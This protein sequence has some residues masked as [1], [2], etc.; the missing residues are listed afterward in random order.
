MPVLLSWPAMAVSYQ[1][2][3]VQVSISAE[4]GA[5]SAE[6]TISFFLWR[7]VLRV[8]KQH[9][10]LHEIKTSMENCTESD[11]CLFLLSKP[12]L[13]PS[14]FFCTDS[15]CGAVEKL[16]SPFSG[17]PPTFTEGWGGSRN[18]RKIKPNYKKKPKR[19]KMIAVFTE[20]DLDFYTDCTHLPEWRGLFPRRE[21]EGQAPFPHEVE[22][23]GK[24][25]KKDF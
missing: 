3:E 15:I 12:L 5:C 1:D 14:L 10:P 20:P 13:S 22:P 17:V 25:E 23:E 16:P 24:W 2:A 7:W 21:Q 4:D 8:K 6:S 18:S 9:M 19:C 11:S